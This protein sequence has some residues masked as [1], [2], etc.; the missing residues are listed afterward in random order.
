MSAVRE[1]IWN[2]ARIIFL[3]EG[4]DGISMRRVAAA[5]GVTPTAI[6]RHFT[7]KEALIT[8]LVNEGFALFET[9]LRQASKGPRGIAGIRSQLD[10]YVNFAIAQPRYYDAMFVLPRKDVR[11][12]PESFQA[13][14]SISFS[15][16][17]D[18]VSVAMEL[19]ELRPGDALEITLTL[20]SLVH[21]LASLYRSGRFGEHPRRFRELS[22]RAVERL[23]DGGL[24]A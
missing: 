7:G 6:Y 14:D 16:I 3:D 23:L 11:R 10:A 8:A 22:R 13:G 15:I 9:K 19:G 12:F 21:G 2:S 20:W 24:T 5:V 17:M 18:E 1:Q 4:V